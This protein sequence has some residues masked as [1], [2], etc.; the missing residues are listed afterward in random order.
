GDIVMGVEIDRIHLVGGAK[1]QHLDGAGGFQLDALQ[2]RVVDQHV[3]V[4]LDFVAPHDVQPFH[5]PVARAYGFVPDAGPAAPVMQL[6]QLDP[7]DAG[8]RVI[9]PDRNGDEGNIEMSFPGSA[10]GHISSGDTGN[11]RDLTVTIGSHY[12]GDKESVGG[13]TWNG[14]IN[15]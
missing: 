6:V 4:R 9:E 12:I 5:A 13:T 1:L 3:P 7:V 14:E 2:V 10:W 11:R 8:D 15:S